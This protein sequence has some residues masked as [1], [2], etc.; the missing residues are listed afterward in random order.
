MCLHCQ[1][2]AGLVIGNLR[3]IKALMGGHHPRNINAKTTLAIALLLLLP[4]FGMIYLMRSILP[5]LL[6]VSKK[7]KILSLQKGF[8]TLAYNLSVI[9]VVMDIAMAM[10]NME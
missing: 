2:L 10:A 8:P 3:G 1:K 9:S 5:R 7:S 6:P 4:Q